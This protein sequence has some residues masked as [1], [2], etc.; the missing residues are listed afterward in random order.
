[1]TLGIAVPTILQLSMLLATSFVQGAP[2]DLDL[3]FD[4]GSALDGTVRQ[5][6][7][8]PD[9]KILIA[10]SF[11]AI[12]GVKRHSLARLNADG[13]GDASFDAG[14]YSA[15][16]WVARQSD[17]KLLVVTPGGLFRLFPNGELDASFKHP[18]EERCG[19]DWCS[20]GVTTVFVQPDGKI[21]VGGFFQVA[22]GPKINYGLAR[23]HPDGQLDE[24]FSAT[25]PPPDPVSGLTGGI[26]AIAMRSDGKIWV[27]GPFVAINGVPRRNV[28]RLHADGRLDTSFHP[29]EAIDGYVFSIIAQPDGKLLLAGEFTTA[30]RANRNLARLNANGSLDTGF[31]S[32]TEVYTQVNGIALLPDGRI[33]FTGGVNIFGWSGERVVRL[34]PNGQRDPSFHAEAGSP[35]GNY[36]QALAVQADGNI[37][38]GG[39]LSSPDDQR[40]R[41]LVRLEREGGLDDGLSADRSLR[42]IADGTVYSIAIRPGGR[43]LAAGTV[44]HMDRSI[45]HGVAQVHPDGQVDA[46]FT[47]EAGMGGVVRSVRLEPSGSVLIGGEFL[48]SS[49]HEFRAVA[50]LFEGGALDPEFNPRLESLLSIDDCPENAELFG[51]DCSTTFGVTALDVQADGKIIVAGYRATMVCTE[52]NGCPVTL[53]HFVGRFHRDGSRDEGFF[54]SSVSGL[55]TIEP[56]RTL[57][58]R[59][60]GRILLA[61]QFAAINGVPRNGIALLRGDGVLDDAFVPMRGLA[62]DDSVEAAAF[63][64]DGRVVLAGTFTPN[65]AGGP[66]SV[67]R[68]LPDGSLDPSFDAGRSLQ[69]RARVLDV[70]P[71]GRVLVGGDFTVV[72]PDLTTHLFIAR[73]HPNGTLDTTFD[74]ERGLDAPVL[75]LARQSDGLLLIGGQFTM[76]ENSLRPRLARYDAR[77]APPP[78]RIDP[79]VGRIA[80]SWPETGARFVLQRALMLE[81]NWSTL[82]V[83]PAAE[84]GRSVV[85]LSLDGTQSFFRLS[86]SLSSQ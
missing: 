77:S 72:K 1:M 45:R 56:V 3:T 53:R 71:D 83:V 14:E 24:S 7:A 10:G 84:G 67:I 68:L 40:P 86:T 36:V 18:I 41:G 73:L 70:Q 66:R 51:Y 32:A 20:H 6:I 39:Y 34:Q 30:N 4:P 47:A 38:I 80:L 5:I 60:D 13:T 33:L 16:G 78:L 35:A 37:L 75:A 69:G 15:A 49:G 65:E 8:Q 27:A 28:A 58:V 61:G 31:I 64:P 59:P 50:R 48:D 79:E 22:I 82:P 21:L 42:G 17:G 2:G 23:L 63:Q 54:P 81:A 85:R 29:A 25:L 43:I 76:A 19:P 74:V 9:G 57:A 26:E 12:R 44:V 11:N 55:G 46:G 62:A 52:I